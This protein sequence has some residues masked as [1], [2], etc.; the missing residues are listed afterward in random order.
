MGVLRFPP[1]IPSDNLAECC[2]TIC[3]LCGA[4]LPLSA[5]RSHSQSRHDLSITKYKKKYGPM[6]IVGEIT[7][8]SCYRCD[9]VF[10]MD[11]DTIAGHVRRAHRMKF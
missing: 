5:M 2:K 10:I 3:E 7:Y 8:H 11:K 1:V 9:K 4:K 6:A